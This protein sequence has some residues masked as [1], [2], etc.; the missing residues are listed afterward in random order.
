[1]DPTTTKTEELEARKQALIA[2]LAAERAKRLPEIHALDEELSL[3]AAQATVAKQIG[4]ALRDAERNLLREAAAE[5]RAEQ[6]RARAKAKDEAR[7]FKRAMAQAWSA[8]WDAGERD[9]TAWE[10]R[11]LPEALKHLPDP[12]REARM[13]A[14]GVTA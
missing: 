2:E 1:M 5:A 14:L 4:R 11:W 3:R 6:A 13:A 9:K 10:K 8:A 12:E 7:A